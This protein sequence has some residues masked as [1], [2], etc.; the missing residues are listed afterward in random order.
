[1]ILTKRYIYFGFFIKIK[2]FFSGT[3]TLKIHVSD[4]DYTML[5]KFDLGQYM[6]LLTLTSSLVNVVTL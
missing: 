2:S 4:I 3:G 1:L 6:N 5:D